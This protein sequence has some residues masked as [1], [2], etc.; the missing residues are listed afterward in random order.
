MNMN[1]S[2]NKIIKDIQKTVE[3]K[4]VILGVSG[5][6]DSSVLAILMQKAIGKKLCCLFVDS[7]FNRLENTRQV[8][9]FLKDHNIKLE[10]VKAKNVFLQ[11]LKN[12]RYTQEKKRVIRNNFIEIFNN[13]ALKKKVDFIAHGTNKNDS[14]LLFERNKKVIENTKIKNFEPLINVD[15]NQIKKIAKYLKIPNETINKFP[16]SS[17]GLARRIVGEV[18]EKKLNYILKADNIFIDLLKKEKIFCDIQNAAVYLYPHVGEK[19]KYF[20]ILKVIDK[21]DSSFMLPINLI[22]K[23]A[24]E[25]TENFPCVSR[26][27]YD[28]SPRD[29]LVSEWE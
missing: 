28:V 27:V 1:V 13:Y 6:I 15:K 17:W 7:G 23:I 26:V 9:N 2:I 8:D 18:T 4:R 16:L 22:K 10:R 5:G 14:E 21:K 3:D 29:I 19:N 24:L 20:I 12:K 11:G 25:I